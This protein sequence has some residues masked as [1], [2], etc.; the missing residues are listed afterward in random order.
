MFRSNKPGPHFHVKQL[1]H[2]NRNPILIIQSLHVVKICPWGTL[3]FNRSVSSSIHGAVKK[4]TQKHRCAIRTRCFKLLP[5]LT[6]IKYVTTTYSPKASLHCYYTI[7]SNGINAGVSDLMV[8]LH[9][10]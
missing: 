6:V 9:L 5:F 3:H 7:K 10:V 8:Q 2:G 4:K 1:S